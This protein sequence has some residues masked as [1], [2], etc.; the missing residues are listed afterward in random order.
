MAVTEKTGWTY[1]YIM[2]GISWINIRMMLADAPGFK[3]QKKQPKKVSGSEL[4]KLL[5]L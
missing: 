2:W 4:A 3:R 5:N 1:H